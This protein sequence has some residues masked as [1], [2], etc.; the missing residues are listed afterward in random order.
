M[1]FRTGVC[2]VALDKMTLTVEPGTTQIK[3]EEENRS[4]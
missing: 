4:F 3:K 1:T 2:L